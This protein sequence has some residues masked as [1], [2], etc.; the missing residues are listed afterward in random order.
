[1]LAWSKLSSDGRIV[2]PKRIRDHLGL[3]ARDRVSFRITDRGVRLEKVQADQEDDPLAIFF[4][5][6]SQ[7]DDLAFANL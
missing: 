2:I 6:N 7:E 1:M 3:R 4:E 5:W